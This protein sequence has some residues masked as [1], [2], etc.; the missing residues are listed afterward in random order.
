[1]K[2]KN[3]LWELIAA[4][5]IVELVGVIGSI[6]TTPSI[7]GWY[8]G[9]TKPSFNPPNWIFGPVWTALFALMGIAVFLIWQQRTKRKK[10]IVALAVFGGQLALNLLWSIIFFG[11]HHP[12]VA[13]IE[14]IFL[15]L[16]IL[17]TIYLFAK[18][19]R[20]AAWLLL[21]YILWVSFAAVLNFSLWQ[22]T[23][24][25]PAPVALRPV[26]CSQEAKLCADGTA[27]VR[28]GPDCEFA[29]CPNEPACSVGESCPIDSIAT[30]SDWKTT[31]DQSAGIYFQYPEKLTTQFI[32]VAEWPP[33]VT[34]LIGN[35]SCHPATSTSSFLETS[36]QRLIEDHNYCVRSASG[37]AA[38][39]TY[40]NYKY[41]REDNG[42][43]LTV[44]FA[45]RYPQCLNYDDPEQTACLN[46]RQTFN[47]D[48]IVDRIANSVTSVPR[49][50]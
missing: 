11:L 4:I 16:A 24:V 38:G 35:F 32:T 36:V 18:I 14:I 34:I 12:G 47:L 21:P 5:V 10:N 8:A 28:T 43:L 17:A 49:Q 46:E 15:W 50:K 13:F 37:A 39:S 42:R 33:R 19:S 30:T 3:K 1:M 2:I 20:T 7:P 44:A 48:S 23:Q 40:T 45:L 22:L 41:S 27:V 25:K 6:F 29:P 26:A 31:T 9:L